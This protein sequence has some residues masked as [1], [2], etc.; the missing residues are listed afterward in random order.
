MSLKFSH[1]LVQESIHWYLS[2]T[3][4]KIRIQRIYAYTYN[5]IAC[6]LLWCAY[7]PGGHPCANCFVIITLWGNPLYV[8]VALNR[9]LNE[10]LF[11]TAHDRLLWFHGCTF[12][13][14][15]SI[16]WT[17]IYVVMGE[18]IKWAVEV[19]PAKSDGVSLLITVCLLYMYCLT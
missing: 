8:Q 19:V 17:S 12:C 1:F 2:K 16:Q 13:S 11:G 6:T 15:K 4:L 5:N 10:Q 9:V 3:F 14:K 7:A 18:C